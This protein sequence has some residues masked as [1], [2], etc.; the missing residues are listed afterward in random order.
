MH[1]KKEE[2][3]GEGE[4][5]GGPFHLKSATILLGGDSSHIVEHVS[6][7]AVYLCDNTCRSVSS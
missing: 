7:S 6:G 4:G 5:G 3:E 2:E 1:N